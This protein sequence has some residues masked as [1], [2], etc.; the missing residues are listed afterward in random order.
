MP[1]GRRNRHAIAAVVER[2]VLGPY[3]GTDNGLHP[4][5]QDTLP[6]LLAADTSAQRGQWQQRLAERCG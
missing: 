4:R 1:I 5:M 6:T 3:Q 2:G